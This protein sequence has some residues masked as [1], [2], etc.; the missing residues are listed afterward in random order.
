MGSRLLVPETLLPDR[1]QLSFGLGSVRVCSRRDTG[2][3]RYNFVMIW[4]AGPVVTATRRSEGHARAFRAVVMFGS[5]GGNMASRL[6]PRPVVSGRHAALPD[7]IATRPKHLV[8]ETSPDRL[9][10]LSA[11]GRVTAPR[12]TIGARAS[13]RADAGPIQAAP[14]HATLFDPCRCDPERF[15][16]TG[17]VLMYEC[18]HTE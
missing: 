17:H 14:D 6:A 1:L 15:W 16:L 8:P 10:R 5:R 7:R 13:Y 9:A 2:R 3:G 18:Y 12:G 11:S 4:P